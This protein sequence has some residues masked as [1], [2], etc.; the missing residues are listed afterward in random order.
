MEINGKHVSLD[1]ESPAHKL[2]TG[3]IRHAIISIPCTLISIVV[4]MLETGWKICGDVTVSPKPGIHYFNKKP[5]YTIT[6]P[7]TNDRETVYF[8]PEVKFN[9]DSRHY[10][11]YLIALQ[12]VN[13]KKL[14]VGFQSTKRNALIGVC[15]APCISYL[16][17]IVGG[18]HDNQTHH[19]SLDFSDSIKDDD[20]LIIQMNLAKKLFTITL[21]NVKQ[22]V[23]IP[24]E[25]DEFK[26]FLQ[27]FSNSTVTL[28]H[29]RF[30]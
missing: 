14:T 18:I 28:L 5:S 17:T 24:H 26:M 19:H 6:C 25:M 21:K 22:I 1:P 3:W 15:I 12:R 29:Y 30:Q 16:T 2:A 23:E 10:G 4:L 8:G 11:Y 20:K 13:N 9:R 7:F 27:L